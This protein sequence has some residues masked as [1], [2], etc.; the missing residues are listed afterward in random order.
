[1]MIRINFKYIYD[2]TQRMLTKPETEWDKTGKEYSSP[3]ETFRNYLLPVAIL[4]SLTIFSFGFFHYT[5]MQTIGYG[6]INLLS[7]ATGIWFA[8]LL[9]KEYLSN[10][11]RD[12]DNIA[13]LLTVYPGA[14]FI[15]FH[16][17]GIAMGN[18]FL[19]QLFT[20]LSFIFIRTL[21]IGIKQISNLPTNQQ[22]NLL[23]IVALEIICIPV[24]ISQ[25][26]MIAFGISAFNI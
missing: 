4:S 10:K 16:S 15:V 7:S 18:Y 11:L 17:L 2:R 25:I 9:T 12:A 20:L 23:V 5:V 1:M 13:L 14:I 8:Y 3:K 24:I 19:G 6:F 22:T 26:L 21:Y